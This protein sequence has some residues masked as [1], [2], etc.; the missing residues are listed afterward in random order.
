MYGRGVADEGGGHF[1]PPRRDVANHG[2]DVV[3][4]R[5]YILSK[6]G[7]V[8]DPLDEVGRV[9]VLLLHGHPAAETCRHCQEPSVS[10]VAGSHHVLGVEHLQKAKQKQKE[11]LKENN[12]SSTWR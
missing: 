6:C 7:V 4:R 10:G 5:I 12:I 11:R 8:G 9:L 3:G 1:E 2:L